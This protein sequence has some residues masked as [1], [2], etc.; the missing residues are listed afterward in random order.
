MSCHIG[1][2]QSSNRLTTY[3]KDYVDIIGKSDINAIEE[4][5]IDKYASV[6]EL[7]CT[8]DELTFKME[9][10]NTE[11]IAMTEDMCQNSYVIAVK[12]TKR[13]IRDVYYSLNWIQRLLWRIL[14]L[15]RLWCNK[16]KDEK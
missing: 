3:C 14:G 6:E 13:N 16:R 15:N 1:G 2:K 12:D 7:E 4:T 10:L 9:K 5:V 11:N 8:K